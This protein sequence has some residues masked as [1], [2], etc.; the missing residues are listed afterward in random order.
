MIKNVDTAQRLAARA[1]PQFGSADGRAAFTFVKHRENY[2]F[3]VDDDRGS[4]ALRLHRSGYRT[5]EEILEELDLVR[6]LNEA[7]VSVPGVRLTTDGGVV[8]AVTD[9]EGDRHQVD[10]LEW[11]HGAAPMGDIGEAFTGVATVE[12][13]QF[14]ALGALIADL[15]DKTAALQR[16]R[17]PVRSAWDSGGLVGERAVWGDP[18]RA[19]PDDVDGRRTIDQAMSQLRS[20]LARYGELP[21]RYGPIHADFTP[22][23]VLVD[24]DRMTIIDFDDS[25]DGY[26]LF[27]LATAAFFY[28]PHP[29]FEV[30]IS[31]LL[32]GYQSVR[33]LTDEDL[34]VWQPML[35]ARGLT[36]LAWASDRLG[37][38]TSEFIFEHL[39][40]PLVEM[41]QA[42]IS[43]RAS[44][45]P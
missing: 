3:R 1:L 18:R 24:G 44:T 36:Y 7:G 34:A 45:A 41:A 42:Y 11:V 9:D 37:D 33:P 32:A 29:Q 17:P 2:V 25:G 10:M 15:H 40:P 16:V 8:C 20:D 23:N 13:S 30:V 12:A 22:E 19:F 21:G 5:E 28:L 26:Y 4:F 31:A 14:H 35:L 39:R 43:S 27:D 38:E 6:A